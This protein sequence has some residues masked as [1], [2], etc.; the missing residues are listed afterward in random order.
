MTK[1]LDELKDYALS[2][3]I[4]IVQDETL[5][6]IMDFIEEKKITSILEIGTA[7]GYSAIS[8]SE[9]KNV[10]RIVTLER[11]YGYAQI[12]D[13]NIGRAE[14]DEIIEVVYLDAL[15]YQTKEHFD[16]LFIDGAKAQYRKCFDRYIDQVDYVIVDN[17]DF[18]GLVDDPGMITNR[19]TRNLVR[20]IAKFKEEILEDSRY[21]CLYSKTGDGIL[22]INKR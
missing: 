20:K 10:K 1:I 17:M 16:L 4:P 2:N 12:A 21:E 13:I 5:S 8:M 14:K 3:K 19:H 15:E 18:H 6:F 7:I 11:N 9:N 22:L